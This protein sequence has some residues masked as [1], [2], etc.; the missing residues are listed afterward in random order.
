MI[1]ARTS[2][3]FAMA[4][5]LLGSAAPALA[6][7]PDLKPLAIGAEAPDFSLPGVDDKT[8][9]LKDYADAKV[10]VVVFT[11]NHCPTAQAYEERLAK[12]YEDYKDK[13]VA[14]V[15]ISPNDPEASAARRAGLHRPGRLA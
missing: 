15:A 14:V 8:H 11:C 9:S 3:L 2:P 12:L 6:D 10:L 7:P 5:L 4:A 1:R 13:G